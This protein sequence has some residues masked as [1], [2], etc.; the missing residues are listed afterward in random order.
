[1][2]ARVGWNLLLLAA[3]MTAAAGVQAQPPAPTTA[4][5][6]PT[7][8]VSEETDDAAAAKDQARVLF[9]RGLEHFQAG[10]YKDAID[11][12]LRAHR[13]FPNPVLSFNAALAYEKMGDSAG[14]LRFYREYLRQD[15]EAG[16]RSQVEEQISV[17]ERKLQDKGLQQVTILSRPEGATVRIDDRPVGVTPWT[18][19]LN[20]GRHAL[21]LRL[22]GYVDARQRFELLAHR[23][24]DVS[25]TL[26]EAVVAP[27]IADRAPA[28]APVS[29]PADTP[30]AGPPADRHRPRVRP[31][32]LV[33]VG[34]GI[35]T[36]GVAGAFEGLRRSSEN[37]VREA[38]TQAARHDAFD[39]M[40]SRQTTAR[41]LAGVGAGITVVGGGV[42]LGIDLTRERS[43]QKTALRCELLGCSI[44]GR[45]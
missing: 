36:L 19:E 7:S 24:L 31:V 16:D 4:D 20:P 33:V 26:E 2:G 45:F 21:R 14:A 30:N 10:R 6:A 42:L 35:A 3:V 15:P 27:P 18:G 41:V 44:R 37:D 9:A 32:T 13:V 29:A 28:P 34:A 23:S 25:V 8:A 11:E 1:M 43:D 22:E 17:L 12:F 39:Q 40:E 38:D 5:A